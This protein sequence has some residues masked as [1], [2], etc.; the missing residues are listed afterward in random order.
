MKN[1]AAASVAASAA[2]FGENPRRNKQAGEPAR[3]AGPAAQGPPAINEE[4]RGG[5]CRRERGRV[6]REPVDAAG[7]PAEEVDR[8][9][10]SQQA[11]DHRR[12]VQQ[13]AMMSLLQSVYRRRPRRGRARPKSSSIA[14]DSP[15]AA[16]WLIFTFDDSHDGV[17]ARLAAGLSADLDEPAGGRRLDLDVDFVGLDFEQ[18]LA[19]SHA[20]T[21]LFDPAQNLHQVAFVA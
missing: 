16:V 1:A 13:L 21:R 5:E 4:R 8:R 15:G 2:A 12:A 10:G 11:A 18:G 9:R 6:R 7:E 20:L 17:E 14:A 19:F 3:P